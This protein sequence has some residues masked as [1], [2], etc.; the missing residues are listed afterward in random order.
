M[1]VEKPDGYRRASN[2]GTGAHRPHPNGEMGWMNDGM[3]PELY[4][5]LY[6]YTSI[7]EMN[8]VE[9]SEANESWFDTDL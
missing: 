8:H 9:N 1:G 5:E 4:N 7:G 3:E 6:S 2:D